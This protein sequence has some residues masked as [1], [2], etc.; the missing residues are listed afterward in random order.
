MSEL[1][2]A[3]LCSYGNTARLREAFTV[4]ARSLLFSSKK[5]SI[6]LQKEPQDCKFAD[7]GLYYSGGQIITHPWP[8]IGVKFDGFCQIVPTSQIQRYK[9]NTSF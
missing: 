7:L 2:A 5:M 6:L 9:V 1:M 4:S 3:L 8:I